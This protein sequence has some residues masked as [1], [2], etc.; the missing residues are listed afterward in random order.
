MPMAAC[1]VN[2]RAAS[3]GGSIQPVAG[4][5]AGGNNSATT[6]I[7][8]QTLLIAPGS[9]LFDAEGAL[10]ACGPVGS[11]LRAAAVRRANLML[12]ASALGLRRV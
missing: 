8:K 4:G 12:L 5:V 3:Y 11:G 6:P 7:A 10:T 9:W 2:L 1:S